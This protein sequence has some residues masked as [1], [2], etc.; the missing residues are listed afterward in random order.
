MSAPTLAASLDNS[1]AALPPE[2][3]PREQG[4]AKARR[5]RLRARVAADD[6]TY[7]IRN[8]FAEAAAIRSWDGPAALMSLCF[9]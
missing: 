7:H 8:D 5:A 4:E 2:G 6:T 3:R 1:A 9:A